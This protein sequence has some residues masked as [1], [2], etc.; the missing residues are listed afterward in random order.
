MAPQPILCRNCLNWF[1][2]SDSGC[3]H[4]HGLDLPAVP[5]RLNENDRRML[6]QLRIAQDQPEDADDGA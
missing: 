1:T 6:K 4:C 3:P 5:Y 2:A